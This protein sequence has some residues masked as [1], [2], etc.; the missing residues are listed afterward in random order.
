M[1]LFVPFPKGSAPLKLLVY[2]DPG[3]EKTRRALSMPGPIYVIDLECGAVNYSDLVSQKDA[4]YLRTKSHSELFLALEELEML[5]A[6]AVG[7]LII[8]PISQVWQSLQN[9]HVQRQ[10]IRK[11]RIA[12]DVFFDVG[13]WGKLKRSYGDI[14]SFLLS[15]PYHV[16]MTARGK[17]KIDEK[18]A[19]IEYSYEGER[20]TS[21]LAN[22][23]IESRRDYDIIIKDRTG[24]YT[25]NQKIPRVSF[26][27]FLSK[28]DSILHT[29]ESD[30]ATAIKDAELMAQKI[31]QDPNWA[32][33]GGKRTFLVRLEELGITYEQVCLF[34]SQNKRPF[35]EKMGEPQRERL[36]QFLSDTSQRERFFD[37]IS[38]SM[39]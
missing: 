28:T 19:V 6:G 20:S 23:V 2:G 26:T 18:G 14:M 22:V 17:D 15:A 31:E 16:I 10:V 38:S 35:P 27:Q 29:M 9:G 5:P 7:T 25:E 32:Y 1:S 11:K 21:F 37:E 3:T 36:L 4:F 8:D 13:T 30:T 24:T 34:C 33:G 39:K 12:E